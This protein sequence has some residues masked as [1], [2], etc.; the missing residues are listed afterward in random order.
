MG[1]GVCSCLSSSLA[2]A[3]LLG[4]ATCK[5]SFW[6]T[7][8]SAVQQALPSPD[9]HKVDFLYEFCQGSLPQSP[10]VLPPCPCQAL[11]E[12]LDILWLHEPPR[13]VHT[14]PASTNRVERVTSP[15]W[16]GDTGALCRSG[17]L[18]FCTWEEAPPVL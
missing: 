14:G 16:P 18:N 2:T 4:R 11:V 15:P 1:H 13:A 7:L 8:L 5:T 17:R 12:G 9:V 10:S 3:A 6:L